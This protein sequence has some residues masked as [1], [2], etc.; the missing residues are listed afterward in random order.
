MVR[1]KQI[2]LPVRGIVID[3]EYQK[4]FDNMYEALS[5]KLNYKILQGNIK[6]S[7]IN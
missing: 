2:R 1:G 6:N 4:Y 5:L 7:Q 3:E